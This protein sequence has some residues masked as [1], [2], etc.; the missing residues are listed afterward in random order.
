M[1]LSFVFCPQLKFFR[2]QRWKKVGCPTLKP[3]K[4]YFLPQD[5]FHV[6]GP[7]LSENKNHPCHTNQVLSA[8]NSYRGNSSRTEK[9]QTK[10]NFSYRTRRHVWQFIGSVTRWPALTMMPDDDSLQPGWNISLFLKYS[11]QFN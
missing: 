4:H 8:R 6:K 1:C 11:N 5:I 2:R 3:P 9:L 7:K 10:R